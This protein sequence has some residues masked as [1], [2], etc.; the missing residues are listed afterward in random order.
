MRAI[1]PLTWNNT[2]TANLSSEYQVHN[3]VSLWPDS[4]NYLYVWSSKR[5]NITASGD[6]TPISSDIYVYDRE[7]LAEL[8]VFRH[9]RTGFDTTMRKSDDEAALEMGRGLVFIKD[10]LIAYVAYDEPVSRDAHASIWCIDEYATVPASARTIT[11]RDINGFDVDIESPMPDTLGG[12]YFVAESGDLNANLASKDIASKLYHYTSTGQLIAMVSDNTTANGELVIA[13]EGQHKG[14]IFSYTNLDVK[15]LSVDRVLP[16]NSVEVFFWDGYQTQMNVLLYETAVEIEKP[17][18]AGSGFYFSMESKNKNTRDEKD[19]IYYWPGVMGSRA[20][21]VWSSDNELEVEEPPLDG[22]NGFY[23]VNVDL[24]STDAKTL[25]STMTLLHARTTG[26]TRVCDLGSFLA[27]PST[28]IKNPKDPQAI[29]A[30]QFQNEFALVVDE[31]HNQLFV[32]AGPVGGK[33]RLTVLDWTKKAAL[34]SGD[35]III[36]FDD[37]EMGGSANIAGMIKFTERQ[38]TGGVRNS[39]SGCDSGL[40]LLAFAGLAVIISS[41]K[42]RT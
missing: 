37:E 33:F 6:Y 11:S 5:A 13:Q 21:C 29:P 36:T 24:T 42:T 1:D 27:P 31:D 19:A 7:T 9:V 34:E 14:S 16:E 22:N 15:G 8:A 41:R 28:F 4:H 2:A 32:G 12:F 40:G 26:S 17:F 3:L 30:E 38:I 25:I 35:N 23:F 18:T 10:G 39:S 20:V